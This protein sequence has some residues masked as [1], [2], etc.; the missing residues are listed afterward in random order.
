MKKHKGIGKLVREKASILHLWMCVY[1]IEYAF[2]TLAYKRKIFSI[3]FD[4]CM[5]QWSKKRLKAKAYVGC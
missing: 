3:F 2:K 1:K 4:F 5:K